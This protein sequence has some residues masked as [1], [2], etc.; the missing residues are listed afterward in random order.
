MPAKSAVEMGNNLF[1]LKELSNPQSNIENFKC[2][3]YFVYA[4]IIMNTTD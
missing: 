4:F 2:Y 3:I 1:F